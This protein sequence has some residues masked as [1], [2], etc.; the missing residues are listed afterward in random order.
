MT[1]DLEKALYY[2]FKNQYTVY[3][4]KPIH[5]SYLKNPYTIH[6]VPNA[7]AK[8]N[9]SLSNGKKLI[10]VNTTTQSILLNLQK[11][12]CFLYDQNLHP[13]SAP[14]FT[15]IKKLIAKTPNPKIYFS[16]LCKYV[17]L[18][19][20]FNF[21]ETVFTNKEDKLSFFQK[22]IANE[23]KQKYYYE[24]IIQK[25]NFNHFN[26]FLD[27]NLTPSEKDDF[28]F[29]FLSKK[30][31]Y[32]KNISD[33]KK[34][35][36]FLL[37]LYEKDNP[38]LVKFTPFLSYLK[39]NIFSNTLDVF[40]RFEYKVIIGVD[41]VKASSTLGIKSSSVLASVKK[42]ITTLSEEEK[43]FSETIK[44]NNQ[45]TIIFYSQQ[46][47]KFQE[48]SIQEVLKELL[49]KQKNEP[50][51]K[52]MKE[53]VKSWYLNYILQKDLPIK[54]ASTKILKI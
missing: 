47:M 54:E 49:L 23:Q 8:K 38:Q 13:T 40:E 53:T 18:H 9:V 17:T 32:F 26:K 44:K 41:L 11:N 20:V 25:L 19:N 46:P 3:R 48:T 42:I 31:S 52:I 28:L 24:S 10:Q 34:V 1:N 16:T 39:E 50:K 22:F 33:N 5:S 36:E 21:M 51:F 12:Q 45:L 27:K 35:S 30:K 14:I 6:F 4:Y 43:I 29:S 2:G 15:E 7:L 37:S